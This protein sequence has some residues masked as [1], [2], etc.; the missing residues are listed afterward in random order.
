MKKIGCY[1][2]GFNIYH[3]LD[4]LSKKNDPHKEHIKWLDLYRLCH[5]YIDE[6]KH[7]IELVKYFTAYQ[8]WRPERVKRHKE[9]IK[10]L[11]HQGVQTILGQFKEKQKYCNLCKGSFKGHEEKESDVN[12]ATHLVADVY[13]R[14]VDTVFVFSRDSDLAGPIRH[15]KDTFPNVHIKVIAPYWRFHSKELKALAHKS[16]FIKDLHLESCRLPEVLYNENNE[17][18][19]KCPTQYELPAS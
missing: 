12:L 11:E 4:E 13:S 9:Y 8:N 5:V 3:A 1:F 10:A 18:I 6:N 7:N 19:A 16:S 17:I 2:D 14:R 15:I